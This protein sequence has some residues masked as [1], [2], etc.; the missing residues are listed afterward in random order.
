M[1]LLVNTIGYYLYKSLT[2]KPLAIYLPTHP[3]AKFT[4]EEVDQLSSGTTQAGFPPKI[5]SVKASI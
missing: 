3:E 5:L 4:K 1:T 2:K